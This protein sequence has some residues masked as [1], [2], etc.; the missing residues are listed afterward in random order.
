M[1]TWDDAPAI[2]TPAFTPPSEP[3]SAYVPQPTQGA[4]ATIEDGFEDGTLD[5]WTI[6]DS[7][8]LLPAVFAAEPRTG[9]YAAWLETRY[10]TIG[11]LNYGNKIRKT[12]AV[13]APC[14]VDV[15][16]WVRRAGG[17][18]GNALAF[19]QVDSRAGPSESEVPQFTR[20]TDLLGAVSYEEVTFSFDAIESSVSITARA[21]N[22]SIGTGLIEKVT[23]DDVA[24][25]FPSPPTWDPAV[26][27]A[28]PWS[29]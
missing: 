9:L 10:I 14:Q 11:P 24:I 2:P 15:A 3:V 13:P 18:P 20:R 5:G 21:Y 16:L 29:T 22:G 7:S 4:L 23:I 1:T 12:F 25:S 17:S 27:P 28:T 8:T 19:F 26:D 6:E